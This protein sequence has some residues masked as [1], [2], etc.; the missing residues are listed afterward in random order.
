M[1]HTSLTS[2]QLERRFTIA[3]IVTTLEDIIKYNEYDMPKEEF[4]AAIESILKLEV[5]KSWTF[6]GAVHFTQ[7][8]RIK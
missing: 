3:G 2:E 4:E 5:T 6:K 1:K 7:I 8:T